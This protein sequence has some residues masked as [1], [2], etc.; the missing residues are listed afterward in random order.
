MLH[1][2]VAFLLIKD[3]DKGV[4][5]LCLL[6]VYYQTSGMRGWVAVFLCLGGQIVITTQGEYFLYGN[7]VT[8]GIIELT[9]STN[10]S[11]LDTAHPLPFGQLTNFYVYVSPD[12]ALATTTDRRIQLQIWRLLNST[13]NE[14]RLVWQQLA[15]VNTS[16]SIG[17]LLTVSAGFHVLTNPSRTITITA[18]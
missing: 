4:A 9:P 18:D 12:A 17:A 10:R 7:D 14:Y 6:S 2:Y 8:N 15:F 5:L 3:C 11:I 1:C 16:S 13:S